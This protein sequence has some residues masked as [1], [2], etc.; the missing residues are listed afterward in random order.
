MPAPAAR[1]LGLQLRVDHKPCDRFGV[2][3]P[4]PAEHDP[5]GHRLGGQHDHLVADEGAQQL[6]QPALH[7]VGRRLG[8]RGLACARPPLN[9]DEL[10]AGREDVSVS[11]GLITG[12]TLG[13][14]RVFGER[15][16]LP[17]PFLDR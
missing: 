6:P 15:P 17:F 3:E 16:V 9:R 8:Q 13:R 10:V 12:V 4:V 1:R 7:R 11:T 5:G 14:L 2:L